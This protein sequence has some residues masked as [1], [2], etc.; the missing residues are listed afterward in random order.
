MSSS[1]VK[2]WRTAFLTLRDENSASPPRATVVRLL[3]KL[4]LSQ[5]HSLVAAAPQLP[6]HEVLS[7][8]SDLTK[9]DFIQH[10]SCRFIICTCTRS[11]HPTLC[12]CWS[13]FATTSLIINKELKMLLTPSLNYLHWYIFHCSC[14]LDFHIVLYF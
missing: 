9:S 7:A 14:G 3:D 2:S 11:S 10:F 1:A 5:S 8:T 12:Y 6:P 13:W 4:I